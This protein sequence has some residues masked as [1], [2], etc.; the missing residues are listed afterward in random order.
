MTT[1]KMTAKKIISLFFATLMVLSCM[2]TAN[3]AG[4]VPQWVKDALEEAVVLKVADKAIV[5]A[6]TVEYLPEGVETATDCPVEYSIAPNEGVSSNT[7]QDGSANYYNLTP[8]TEYKVTAKVTVSETE[9]YTA[10][11]VRKLKNG[12][13]PPKSPVPTVTSTTIVVT[14]SNGAVFECYD[15]DGNKI[16]AKT[17]TSFA[18][19]KPDTVYKIVSYYPESKDAYASEKVSIEATTLKAAA[20]APA[21][22]VLKDKTNDSIVIKAV[23]G[24]EYSIDNGKTWTTTGVFT[25]LTAN[26]KY[27]IVARKTFVASKQ[28]PSLVSAPFAVFTNKTENYN[29]KLDNCTI[30]IDYEKKIYAAQPYTFAAV[31][32]KPDLAKA[33]YGDTRYVPVSFTYGGQAGEFAPEAAGD[34]NPC[35]KLATFTAP[36]ENSNYKIVVTYQLE[37][38][39]GEKWNAVLDDKGE[40]KI[41]SKE[42]SVDVKKPYSGIRE[43][44][45]TI[46]NLVTNTIPNLIMRLFGIF[47]SALGE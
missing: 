19:L 40:E 6:P 21:V 33:Q 34:K 28:D 8:G 42:F 41:E 31:G 9:S 23:K 35:S 25:G 20:K 45:E 38:F 39:D 10:E 44:F 1:S 22:P 2:V 14:G 47:G 36:A 27:E 11:I 5:C 3:A 43:F 30:E 15:K 12:Q 17:S 18:G 16:A 32:D 13:L 37:E 4:E 24:E 29:A 26:T 7:L 46:I